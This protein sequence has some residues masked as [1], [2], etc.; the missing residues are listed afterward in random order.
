MC[1]RKNTAP[2]GAVVAVRD[3][4]YMGE[5]GNKQWKDWA[6]GTPGSKARGE[7]VPVLKVSSRVLND[8]STDDIPLDL[9][10]CRVR[11]K[12]RYAAVSC[13]MVSVGR[14]SLPMVQW[15]PLRR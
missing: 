13:A 1:K 12:R 7:S 4:W 15:A 10:G 14:R 2:Y 3:H 11:R 5:T 6:L 9:N 8:G